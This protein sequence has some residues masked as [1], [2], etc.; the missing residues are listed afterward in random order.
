M[1]DGVEE[2]LKGIKTE[3]KGMNDRVSRLEGGQPTYEPNPNNGLKAEP[4]HLG[5]FTHSLITDDRE[6]IYCP[7]C[8]TVE[9]RKIPTIE[10]EKVVEKVDHQPPANWMPIPTKYEDI[11]KVLGLEHPDN[12][13]IWDCP[14]CAP[15]FTKWLNDNGYDKVKRR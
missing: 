8:G 1:T 11:E 13:T 15:K 6:E 9:R 10:K 3:L 7:T 5:A 4:M 2:L 12:K 14:H